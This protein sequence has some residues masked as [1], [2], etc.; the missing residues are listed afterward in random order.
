MSHTDPDPSRTARNHRP[1]IIAIIFALGI[2]VVVFLVFGGSPPAP[3]DAQ[4]GDPVGTAGGVTEAPSATPDVSTSPAAPST[5][6]PATG[7]GTTAPAGTT[8]T[9][10]SN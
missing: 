7:A 6:A 5:E 1:A 8:T 4:S 2:A 9:A 10:P 3:S